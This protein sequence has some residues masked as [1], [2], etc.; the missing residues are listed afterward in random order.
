MR[1]VARQNL[2]IHQ[3]VLYKN[4]AYAHTWEHIAILVAVPGSGREQAR[5][6]TLG[7]HNV[8]DRDAAVIRLRLVQLADGL[9]HLRNLVTLHLCKQCCTGASQLHPLCVHSAAHIKSEGTFGHGSCH[10]QETSVGNI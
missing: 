8:G 9:R 4:G 5:V 2:G 6:V 3:N 1:R 10:E 7:C